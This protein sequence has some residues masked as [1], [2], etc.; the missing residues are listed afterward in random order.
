MKKLSTCV[1]LA[2]ALLL[3]VTSC[4]KQ[5]DGKPKPK[6][7]PQVKQPAPEGALAAKPDGRPADKP[8]DKPAEKPVATPAEKPVAKPVKPAAI[9]EPDKVDLPITLTVAEPAGVDQMSVP[10]TGGIPLPWGVY[11]KDQHFWVLDG[12]KAVANQVRPLVVDEEGYLRWVLLDFQT[13]L[14]AGE[15][16]TFTFTFARWPS[17]PPPALARDT[18]DGV[19]VDTGAIKFTVAKDKPFSLFTTLSAGGKLVLKG[20]EVIYTDITKDEVR[21]V[22]D[23]PTSIVIEYNGPMRTTVCVRAGFL[24]DEQTKLTAIARITAWKGRSDVHV[25]YSLANSNKQH[26]TFRRIK[27]SSIAMTLVGGAKKTLIGATTPQSIDGAASVAKGLNASSHRQGVPGHTLVTSGAKTVWSA[28]GAKEGANGWLLARTANGGVFVCDRYFNE[29][30][31]RAM[32]AGK[33]LVLSGV[34]PR[35]DGPKGKYRG[36]TVTLGHPMNDKHRWLMDCSHPISQYVIDFAAPAD[37]KALDAKAQAA[38]EYRVIASAPPA[39]YFATEGLSVGKFGTQADEL[40]ANDTWGW[41]YDKRRIPK[42]PYEKRRYVWG[43]DNHYETEE[44]IVESILLMYFRTGGRAFYRGAEAWANNHMALQQWRTDGWR[45]RDGGVWWTAGGPIGNRPT[46]EKDPITGRRNSCPATWAKAPDAKDLGYLANAKQCYCHNWGPGL[47][48]WFCLTGDRDALEAA[49]DSAEQNYDTQV[50]ARNKAPGNQKYFSRDFTR[51][52]RLVNAARLIAPDDEFLRHASDYLAAIYLKRAEK[53]PRGLTKIAEKKLDM[54][55]F[56]YETYVGKEGVAALKKLGIII[57]PY[58]GALTDF[59]TRAR[60]MPTLNPHTWMFPPLSR[61]MECYYRVSGNEDALDWFIAYGQAVAHLL[62]QPKHHAFSGKICLD[63]PRKGVTMDLASWTM[64]KPLAEGI[65][66]SGYLAGFHPDLP[67]RAYQYTGEEFLRERAKLVWMG[68]SHRGYQSKKMKPLDRIGMWANCNG[69]H[70]ESVG[71]TGKTFYVWAHARKDALP[72]EP[73]DDLT[74]KVEDDGSAEPTGGKI[75]VSFTAPKDQGG[76]RVARY[77]VKYSDKPI[78]SYQAFLKLWAD[79]KDAKHTNWFMAVNLS[80]ETAPK[81]PGE[82]ETLVL[83]G[84]DED[85]VPKYFAVRAF[86]NFNNRSDV[87][88]PAKP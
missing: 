88:S 57:D 69:P 83:T 39:W 23:K 77:Q 72:P 28:A 50:R 8:K 61:A 3:A 70:S 5:E 49:I 45:W 81:K 17:L 44:D 55:R 4:S 26:Y 30:A 76:G 9:L 65:V 47:A 74:V 64:K 68:G 84:L 14:K 2:C 59:K 15:K 43:E 32:G 34:I 33:A 24:N 10:V 22:A 80:G 53:E 29:D 20:G 13:D 56:K 11:K 63:F 41:K 7:Q 71:F 78:V 87:S 21:H 54:L 18:G 36:K 75:T 85:V 51:S 35:F 1:A 6:P 37:V 27:E 86:D 60:W 67:A 73:V 16:K 40:K 66:M 31:P 42:A 52:C 82:R 19:E 62:Y 48:G 12:D 79:N 58:N 46:R 25:K 38:R